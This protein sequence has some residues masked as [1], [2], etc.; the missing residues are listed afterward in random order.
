M[1][2]AIRR[3]WA[4]AAVP[5]VS[6]VLALLLGSLLIIVSSLATEKALNLLLP[7]IAYESL[8]Q[9]ALGLSF[10]DVTGR[11]VTFNPSINPDQAARALT[12]TMSAASPL[13]LA[14]L[15]VGVGFKAG[16]FNI[17]GQGQILVGGFSAAL[18]GALMAQQPAPVAVTIAILAGAL[19]GAIYGFIPG[20]LKAYTGAHEVVSTIML[21]S[22][23]AFAIVGLVNDIFK[24]VGPSF[25]RTADVGNAAMPILFGRNGNLGIVITLVL[26]ALTWVLIYR[27]PLGFEIRT[28]GANPDAARYAGMNPRRLIVLTMSLCGLFAGLAGTFEILALG[29]YPAVFGTTLGYAGITV[30]L[31]GRAHPVGILLAALLLGGMRAGAPAMQITAKIPIEIIDVIQGLI[32]LFLAAEVVI[33]R[34][35]RNRTERVTPAEIGTVSRT[36]GETTI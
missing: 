31:L 17:G 29:Y 20:F 8:F 27:T 5:V 24:I 1:R 13:A 16:L 35:L 21:N 18:A 23:A 2:P 34:L 33:R 19:G 36:Y 12:N 6:I 30:A 7:L 3:V 32:L 9:G 10:L 26:V 4:L 28:V 14:G 22:L 15:A 11:A 25:A